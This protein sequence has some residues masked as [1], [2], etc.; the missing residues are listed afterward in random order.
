MRVPTNAKNS[1]LSVN[2]KSSRRPRRLVSG[3]I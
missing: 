3:F 1:N 2:E